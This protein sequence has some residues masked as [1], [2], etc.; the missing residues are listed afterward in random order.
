M[1]RLVTPWLLLGAFAVAAP[2]LALDP[3]SPAGTGGLELVDHA[4]LSLQQHRRLLIVGAHPDDEDTVLLT[5][6]SRG[7]GGEAAYLSL[8]RGEGGQNLVGDELGEA[9][10]VLRTEELLAAREIDGARQFFTRAYDF[11]YTRSLEET[12]SFWP[13][14]ELLEDTV[15]VIRR[16]RP[17]VVVSVFPPDR[18]E[19]HGQHQAAGVMAEAAFHAAG[20]QGRFPDLEAE[21]LLPWRPRFLYREAWWDPEAATL[22]V[23]AGHLDPFTGRTWAQLAMEGRSQHRSQSMGRLQDA[24]P[25]PVLLTRLEAPEGADPGRLFGGM[26]TGLETLAGFTPAGPL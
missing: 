8:T 24:G 26:P 6:L 20:E 14:E 2:L 15:R 21:G 1:R 18:R 23:E 5:L 12:L 3:F 4:L 16:F 19:G 25:R 10:G 17:L 9:L 11:G 13:R 7:Q 22:S